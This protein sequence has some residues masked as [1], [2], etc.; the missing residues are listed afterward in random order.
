MWI[1]A[2]TP[3][4]RFVSDM[5]VGIRVVFDPFALFALPDVV[6]FGIQIVLFVVGTALLLHKQRAQLP[7]LVAAL[8]T[9]IVGV[10]LPHPHTLYRIEAL[11]LLVWLLIS[12]ETMVTLSVAFIVA[13]Y[14]IVVSGPLAPGLMLTVWVFVHA[15]QVHRPR[16]AHF[17]LLAS[18]VLAC[19]V[20]PSYPLPAFP[21]DARFTSISALTF[22][23][24]SIVGPDG[25]HVAVTPSRYF[26]LL[27]TV[28]QRLAVLGLLF[29]VCV[30]LARSFSH[31]DR[32]RSIRELWGWGFLT[33][34]YT[35][36]VC[37]IW[38]FSSVLAFS[39][40][41]FLRRFVPGV[42]MFPTPWLWA[43][44][45]VWAGLTLLYR[46][47]RGSFVLLLFLLCG[48]GAIYFVPTWHKV[49]EVRSASL[50]I[51]ATP[52]NAVVDLVGDWALAPVREEVLRELPGGELQV[53][54]EISQDELGAMI[55]G[56]PRSRWHSRQQGGEWFDITLSASRPVRAL[57][58]RSGEAGTDF[59]RGIR[60]ATLLDS[61]KWETVFEQP[62]W[63]GPVRW[64]DDGYPYFGHQGDVLVVLP[65]KVNTRRLR[66]TQIG[67]ESFFDWSVSDLKVSVEAE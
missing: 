32:A 25:T 50:P 56:D 49:S 27:E 60:I 33:A 64:T 9:L 55:D 3:T 59:P 31:N 5:N 19:L 21:G 38:L 15:F 47:V 34:G 18:F 57:R 2:I 51:F 44:L 42:G 11:P 41:S 17:V 30:E 66:V 4:D 1:A 14:T 16:L 61:G 28:F 8:I 40:F 7:L 22:L 45:W 6:A 52:S 65:Q 26:E 36:L 37:E 48:I 29:G 53:Q 35:L 23:P 67:H 10:A 24:P 46:N 43:S 62:H 58:M 39:P 54:S 12:R 20:L 13:L 63:Y